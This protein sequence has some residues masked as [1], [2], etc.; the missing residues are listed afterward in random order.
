MVQNSTEDGNRHEMVSTICNYI[1]FYY[2]KC[3]GLASVN[4]NGINS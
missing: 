3:V 1:Y 4:R 2:L